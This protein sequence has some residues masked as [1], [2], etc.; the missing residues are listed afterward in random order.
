MADNL[1]EQMFYRFARVMVSATNQH[2]INEGLADECLEFMAQ[3]AE[4]AHDHEWV[5]Q[6]RD[7]LKSRA[8][9]LRAMKKGE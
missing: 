3:E 2:E 4:R 5:T 9:E 1:R 8:A 7:A 6:S